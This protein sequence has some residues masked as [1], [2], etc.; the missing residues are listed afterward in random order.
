MAKKFWRNQ[1]QTFHCQGLDEIQK[2]IN[3]FNKNNF[4]IA[5]QI[6]PILKEG[7]NWVAIVYFKIKPE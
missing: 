6:F 1:I 3:E 4:V 7:Y 5:T 2:R